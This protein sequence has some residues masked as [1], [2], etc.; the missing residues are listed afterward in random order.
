MQVLAFNGSPRKEGNTATLA[1]KAQ[2][3]ATPGVEEV[4]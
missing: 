4:N 2:T 1:K 3:S